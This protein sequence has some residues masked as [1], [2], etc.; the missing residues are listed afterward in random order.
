MEVEVSEWALM[1]YET[2]DIAGPLDIVL[3]LIHIS[4]AHE[5]VL[6]LVCRLLLEKKQTQI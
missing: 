5:T 6:D 1:A 3:S 4:R 2:H